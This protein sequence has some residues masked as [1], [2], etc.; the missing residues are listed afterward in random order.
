MY[1]I[2]TSSWLGQVFFTLGLI[3]KLLDPLSANAKL[4]RENVRICQIT[5]NGS[6]MVRQYAPSLVELATQLLAR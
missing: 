6:D 5:L 3:R 2:Y 1:N 4:A